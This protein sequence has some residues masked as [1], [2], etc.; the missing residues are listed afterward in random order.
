[1]KENEDLTR[2]VIIYWWW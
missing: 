2:E 1:M